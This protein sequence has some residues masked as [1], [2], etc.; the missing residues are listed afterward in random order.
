ML[1]IRSTV[2]HYIRPGTDLTLGLRKHALE[3]AKLSMH[4]AGTLPNMPTEE[5]FTALGFSSRQM[6]MLL[7]KPLSYN[8]NDH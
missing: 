8:G 6:A 2:L 5:V 4:R 1:L 7:Y 3:S